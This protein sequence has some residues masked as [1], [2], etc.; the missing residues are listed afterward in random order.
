MLHVFKMSTSCSCA[1]LLLL[2]GP[3]AYRLYNEQVLMC[4]FMC[5]LLLL[6]PPGLAAVLPC[7]PVACTPVTCWHS[8]SCSVVLLTAVSAGFVRPP[9]ILLPHQTIEQYLAG[10][11]HVPQLTHLAA[12][13]QQ[14][15]N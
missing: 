11:Q 12:G 8:H 10:S 4:M 9:A 3:G 6:L 2:P 5:Q 15:H 7:W 14:Q 13:Q 1:A